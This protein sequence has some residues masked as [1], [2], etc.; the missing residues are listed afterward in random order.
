[1]NSSRLRL[2]SIHKLRWQRFAFSW[3]PTPLHWLFLWDKCW[4]KV[5]LPINVPRLVNEVCKQPLITWFN[6]L[7]MRLINKNINSWNWSNVNKRCTDSIN[8]FKI[9]IY[10]YYRTHTSHCSDFAWRYAEGGCGTKGWNKLFHLTN[11]QGL[12]EKSCRM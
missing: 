8:S 1:M 6:L 2:G 4:Q 3:P 5:D 7:N 12:Y 9:D 10:L 11:D